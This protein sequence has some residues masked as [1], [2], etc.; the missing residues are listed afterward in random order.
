MN[1]EAVQPRPVVDAAA[2]ETRTGR[3]IAAVAGV[4]ALIPAMLIEFELIDWS[5]AQVA[6][7]TVLLGALVVLAN[8]MAS[9]QT[10]A[11]ALKVEQEVTPIVSPQL[12]VV[13]PLQVK[14]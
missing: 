4:L 11:N 7:Y 6:Q 1:G 8:V 14:G 10:K 13:Q 3:I 9:N 5:G 2:Q 12:T